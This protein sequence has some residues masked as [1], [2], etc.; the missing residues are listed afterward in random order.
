MA[1]RMLL[2][3][4]CVSGEEEAA[5][6][7]GGERA[8]ADAIGEE[9]ETALEATM[10][11]VVDPILELPSA[12]SIRAIKRAVS[13]ADGDEEVIDPIDGT[14]KLNTNVALKGE[15]ES[16]MSV[17]GGD[18]NREQIQR[19]RERLRKKETKES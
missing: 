3:G 10:R 7:V 2:L 15:F 14:S 1:L 18:S 9:G 11:L 17:W 16:F 12:H 8:Y 4:E 5:R 6:R 19:A 13:A